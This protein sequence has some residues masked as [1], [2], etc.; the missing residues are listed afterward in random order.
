MRY[1]TDPRRR[2]AKAMREIGET[3]QQ[4][5]KHLRESFFFGRYAPAL[6]PQRRLVSREKNLEMFGQ[7]AVKRGTIRWPQ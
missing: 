7:Q 4:T 3:I 1:C 5:K 6:L 2:V